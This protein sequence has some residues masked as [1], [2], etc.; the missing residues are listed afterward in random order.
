MN[1]VEVLRLKTKLNQTDFAKLVGT[2]QR[3][4]SRYENRT[5]PITVDKLKKWCE[6]LKIDIKELF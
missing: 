6:I 1:E 5:S 3:Q 2:T 4:V